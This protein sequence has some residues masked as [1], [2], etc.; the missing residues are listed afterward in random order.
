MQLIPLEGIVL[1][2]PALC[3]AQGASK[4]ESEFEFDHF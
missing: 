4:A 3:L 2:H 1:A